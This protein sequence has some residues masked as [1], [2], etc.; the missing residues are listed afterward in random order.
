M[1]RMPL[2]KPRS[3]LIVDDHAVVRRGLRQ[4]VV[5]ECDGAVVEEVSTGQ[6]ALDAVRLGD[7]ALVILD[8][9]LPD[10]NG[11]EVLKDLQALRPALPV[12]I[13]SHHAEEQYAARAF[14][15]GAAGY[16]TKDSAAKELSTAIRKVMAGGRYV[17]SSFAERLAGH[18]TGDV[19]AAAHEALSDR[20]HLVL[21]EMARGKTVSQIAD[22]LAL[23]VK[24]VSTYRT[25]LL[26]KLGLAN[27]AEL[28]RHALDH[29]LVE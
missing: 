6:A 8:I 19:S 1:P 9:N 4:V 14:K 20:E 13:L 2:E 16:L 15:A 11:L 26:E 21:C 24:T 29:R 10:K 3:F 12:L 7:W 17:S 25:R 5:E 23:S 27:N 18:L 28:M 22:E